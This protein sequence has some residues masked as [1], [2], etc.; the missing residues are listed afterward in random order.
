MVGPVAKFFRVG[1][2][3][4]VRVVAVVLAGVDRARNIRVRAV[5]GSAGVEGVAILVETLFERVD[6]RPSHSVDGVAF[7]D[8]VVA[9][10]VNAVTDLGDHIQA[11]VGRAVTVIVATVALFVDGHGA[12]VHAAAELAVRWDDAAQSIWTPTF[13]GAAWFRLWFDQDRTA[14]DDQHQHSE[15]AFQ[16]DLRKRNEKSRPVLSKVSSVGSASRS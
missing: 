10:V 1:V 16:N 4:A 7:I 14:Q 3:V 13:A 5:L 9:V 12:S 11:F 15:G 6:A 2:D 8:A